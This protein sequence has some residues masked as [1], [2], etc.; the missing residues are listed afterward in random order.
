MFSSYEEWE[1]VTKICG[2]PD[3]ELGGLLK[4]GL[5]AYVGPNVKVNATGCKSNSVEHVAVAPT[6]P[7]DQTTLL[8][9]LRMVV[10][11]Q[12]AS[13]S[14]SMDIHQLHAQTTTT[15]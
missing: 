8:R 12:L 2:E 3:Y 7:L 15:C 1:C 14:K 9:H 6:M 13:L 5:N 4:S 11:S 10:W